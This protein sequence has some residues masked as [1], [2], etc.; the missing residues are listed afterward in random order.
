[1][2]LKR[3]RKRGASIA[4]EPANCRYETRLLPPNR[5]KVQG[6]LIALMRRY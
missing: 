5:V 3:I 1:V 6:R 4:L 2:T